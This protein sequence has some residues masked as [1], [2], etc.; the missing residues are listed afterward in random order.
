MRRSRTEGVTETKTCERKYLEQT[1]SKIAPRG[2][3]D[4]QL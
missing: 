4:V 3:T 1:D 2:V